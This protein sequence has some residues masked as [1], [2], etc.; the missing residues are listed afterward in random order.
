MKLLLIADDYWHPAEVLTRGLAFL[1]ENGHTLDVVMDAKDIVTADMLRAYDTVIIAKGNALVNGNQHAWFDDGVTLVGPSGYREYV[2]NGGSLLALHAGISFTREDCPEMTDFLGAAFLMH[3]KQCPVEIRLTL[4]GH[5]VCEGVSDFR[6]RQDE[7]YFIERTEGEG[8]VFAESVSAHG[9][10]PAGIARTLGKGRLC[11][12][13]PG[14]NMYV[15]QNP[16]FQRLLL[17]AVEWTG[18]RR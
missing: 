3:P 5:P 18:F 11:L 15:Y 13:T 4:P 9:V 10:Q 16:M 12:L 2:E 1:R 7:H 6:I 8:A 14:H 17:N